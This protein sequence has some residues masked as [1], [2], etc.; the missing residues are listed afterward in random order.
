MSEINTGSIESDLFTRLRSGLV[1]SLVSGYT[2]G[3]YPSYPNISGL[4]SYP[5]SVLRTSYDKNNKTF[6]GTHIYNL[7]ITL[8]TYGLSN[9]QIS[10][11]TQKADNVINDNSTTFGFEVIKSTSSQIVDSFV[12][13]NK[14][15]HQKDLVV[16]GRT[17]Q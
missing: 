17:I 12:G 10:E 11:C 13:G 6:S 14:V 4:I 9:Q 1:A 2:T 5:I 7:D 16:I 8:T 15:I 3:I